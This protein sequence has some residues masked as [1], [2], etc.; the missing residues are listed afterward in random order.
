ML[1]SDRAKN[2]TKILDFLIKT[3][4]TKL[5]LGEGWGE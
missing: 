5:K 1:L 4:G 3:I 2:V